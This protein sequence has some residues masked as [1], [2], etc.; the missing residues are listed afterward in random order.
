MDTRSQKM[1]LENA[2]YIVIASIGGID[3]N[4]PLSEEKQAAQAAELNKLLSGYPRGTIIGKD[5]AIGRYMIGEHELCMQKTSYHIAFPRKP[6]WV[7]GYG[8]AAR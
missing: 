3:P 5:T 2:R 6:E 4:N 8:R 1:T 7:D